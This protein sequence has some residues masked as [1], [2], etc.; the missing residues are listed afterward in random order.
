[1]H[2]TRRQKE[3][4]TDIAAEYDRHIERQK[5]LRQQLT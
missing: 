2:L 3:I 5:Q 4:F 1:M